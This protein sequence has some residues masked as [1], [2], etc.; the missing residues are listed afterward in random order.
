MTIQILSIEFMREETRN[1]S[2]FLHWRNGTREEVPYV[3]EI[4]TVELQASS[5]C[6]QS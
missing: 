5:Q 6:K 4:Q 3:E 2:L 1:H